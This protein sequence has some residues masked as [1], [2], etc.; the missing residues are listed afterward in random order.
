MNKKN[1]SEIASSL[2]WKILENGGSQGVQFVVSVFLARLLG[3]GEYGIVAIVLIF[4]TIA[5]VLVQNG[6]SS[7]LIQK[8]KADD[9]DFSSVLIFNILLSLLIYAV[10]FLS[11]PVIANI[12]NRN[13]LVLI[14]RVM[15]IIIIPGSI[16]SVQNSYIVRN[17]KFKMLF[18]ATFLSSVISGAVSV[19]MA[20][21]DARVWAL[22]F[23]QIVY[24]FSLLIILGAGIRFVPKLMFSLERLG[25]MF[26]FGSKLLAASL[27][28][29]IFTNI[30]G[31]IIGKA[32][33]EDMLGAFNRGEQFPKLVVTN[34]SSAIQSVLLP[35]MSKNQDSKEEI[36]KL[37][38]SSVRLS[39][40]VVAPMM[41]GLAAV[42][43]NLILLLLGTKWST[44]IPFLQMM[45]FSY[46]FWPI[47]ISN[48]QALNAMGRS[49]I[50]L[51]LEIIKK[52]IGIAILIIGIRYNVFI[53]VGLKAFS[54]LIC[55][56]INAAPNSKLLGYT[57]KEQSFDALSSFFPAVVMGICIYAAGSR[58][59]TGII[60]LGVQIVLGIFIYTILIIVLKNENLKI[61]L[62][63]I[64]KNG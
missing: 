14:I 16:I 62:D 59:G 22:A 55:A 57:L 21:Q 26:A 37:L 35:V 31:L 2:F 10:L 49:D 13:E 15:G 45:C 41:C 53:F 6:F 30:H 33:S 4:T 48:L 56:F 32:Y 7:A 39:T 27:I 60:S 63:T 46:A 24:Y 54:D 18:V 61:I 9:L 19:V 29:T 50:F 43:N 47:H 38:K 52:A 3:P 5:N 12:Y 11:A 36:R 44:A 17:M 40:F 58:I 51:K 23:Q 25:T 64:R 1:K 42:S 8:Q 28:D 20:L 34:L